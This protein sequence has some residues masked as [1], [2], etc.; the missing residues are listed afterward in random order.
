MAKALGP[1][2]GADF[3]QKK[4]PGSFI[5]ATLI[6]IRK[7]FQEHT[8]QMNRRKIAFPSLNELTNEMGPFIVDCNFR[9]SIFDKK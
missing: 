4:A 1:F 2:L 6:I 8:L 5:I 7:K 3:K 9:S